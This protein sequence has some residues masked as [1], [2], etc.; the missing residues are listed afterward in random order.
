VS[1]RYARSMADAKSF[2][3]RFKEAISKD[4]AITGSW[5]DIRT[6]EAGLHF[7]AKADHAIVV[8]LLVEGQKAGLEVNA[9]SEIPLV[10]RARMFPWNNALSTTQVRPFFLTIPDN[11]SEL[12]SIFLEVA[13]VN[14]LW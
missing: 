2:G 14:D 6:T 12:C 9:L 4:K 8:R 10:E 7:A 11:L 1:M 13:F 3:R 5:F